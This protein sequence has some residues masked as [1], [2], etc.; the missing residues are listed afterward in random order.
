MKN[1][2]ELTTITDD[3]RFGDLVIMYDP[4]DPLTRVMKK[5]KLSETLEE[6]QQTIEQARCRQEIN[7]P[8][9]LRLIE[10]DDDQDNLIASVYFEFPDSTLDILALTHEEVV[11]LFHDILQ[12]IVYL[13]SNKM[14]HGDIR[15]DY[16]TFSIR[17]NCYKLLDRLG[18]FSNPIQCQLNNINNYRTLYMAP[19]VFNELMKQSKKIKQNSYKSESF[20]LGM[21]VLS[22]YCDPETIQEIYDFDKGVFNHD[23][24]SEVLK[25]V[26][27]QM[28]D[29]LSQKFVA[30][31]AKNVLTYE[32]KDRLSPQDSLEQ[33]LKIQEVRSLLSNRLSV[34]NIDQIANENLLTSQSPTPQPVYYNPFEFIDKTSAQARNIIKAELYGSNVKQTDDDP[35][36]ANTNIDE[37]KKVS[38]T[39]QGLYKYSETDLGAEI[40]KY[41]VS[42][43]ESISN[44]KNAIVNSRTN[45]ARVSEA[46]IPTTS[47][48]NDVMQ[49]PR[50]SAPPKTSETSV[51]PSVA[52][53]PHIEE[54]KPPLTSVQSTQEPTNKQFDPNQSQAAEIELQNELVVNVPDNTKAMESISQPTP[55]IKRAPTQ[56]IVSLEHLTSPANKNDNYFSDN[57]QYFNNSA[58]TLNDQVI[59][60]YSM[61]E[62]MGFSSHVGMMGPNF[63]LYTSMPYLYNQN[64]AYPPITNSFGKQ[65]E[66][67]NDSDDDMGQYLQSL[68]INVEQELKEERLEDK[69]RNLNANSKISAD[70]LVYREMNSAFRQA[71]QTNPENKSR[72]KLSE[73]LRETTK[74]NRESVLS[75]VDKTKIAYRH[76]TN[77][78][79]NESERPADLELQRGLSQNSYVYQQKRISIS[80]KT[81]QP[82]EDLRIEFAEFDDAVNSH[83]QGFDRRMVKQSSE[84]QPEINP[85]KQLFKQ[86]TEPPGSRV[87]DEVRTDARGSEQFGNL[88]EFTNQDQ[89]SKLRIQKAKTLISTQPQNYFL[90]KAPKPEQSIASNENPQLSQQKHDTRIEQENRKQNT[91]QTHQYVDGSQKEK[92]ESNQSQSK[93]NKSKL[94]GTL[95]KFA[96]E[97]KI[98]FDNLEPK[99]AKLRS[100]S[101]ILAP[102]KKEIT[103]IAKVTANDDQMVPFNPEN[104]RNKPQESDNQPTIQKENPLSKSQQPT[105]VTTGHS[106]KEKPIRHPNQPKP[107]KVNENVGLQPHGHPHQKLVSAPAESGNLYLEELKRYQPHNFARP[108]QMEFAMSSRQFENNKPIV[109]TGN[110]VLMDPSGQMLGPSSHRS[111][112]KNPSN[113]A[114]AQR[115]TKSPNQTYLKVVPGDDILGNKIEILIPKDPSTQAT[116]D[117]NLDNVDKADIQ[118]LQNQ[119]IFISGVD[120]KIVDAKK[121]SAATNL[122]SFRQQISKMEA[123]RQSDSKAQTHLEAALV[124]KAKLNLEQQSPST[125]QKTINHETHKQKTLGEINADEMNVPKT[126][127]NSATIPTKI[128]FQSNAESPKRSEKI[129][130]VND[131]RYYSNKDVNITPFPQIPLLYQQVPMVPGTIV[132]STYQN[133]NGSKS[134]KLSVSKEQSSNQVFVNAPRGTPVNGPGV[135]TQE[136]FFYDETPT[137]TVV[138]APTLIPNPQPQYNIY[139][140]FMP[141]TNPRKFV[142][143][144]HI[145]IQPNTIVFGKPAESEKIVRMS[146]SS[147]TS[148]YMNG[149]NT[150]TSQKSVVVQPPPM[151]YQ[152]SMAPKPQVKN[153]PV[154]ANTV[155]MNAPFPS[156]QSSM[157]PVN[158]QGPK[159]PQGYVKSHEIVNPVY[160]KPQPKMD[161]RNFGSRP[162]SSRFPQPKHQ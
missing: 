86:S 94:I 42:N 72:V 113:R 110:Q 112:L 76:T 32:E 15:S 131:P 24:F 109:V 146:H 122:S 108:V 85:P 139:Q 121:N 67:Q 153:I 68:G 4:N 43:P 91:I 22:Y 95:K 119:D 160:L 33:L 84:P 155:W 7:H 29:L 37:D 48:N 136:Y 46:P 117:F 77:L 89:E 61:Y 138:T 150:I 64:P 70:E 157:R 92:T 135:T 140:P 107:E 60:N 132:H 148:G 55:E 83:I 13:Q 129:V 105:K 142:S 11:L 44:I 124:D 130:F 123:K 6:H 82:S 98:D 14:I 100:K 90:H 58:P 127:K 79:N 111:P 96:E 99:A 31:L 88:S 101:P 103:Q 28:K 137:Q 63:S 38:T 17:E 151:L 20:A 8:N 161:P 141:P 126:Y 59:P 36:E 159:P 71:N 147:Q 133:P 87:F 40:N 21:N 114:Q 45:S 69:L 158:I 144:Q 19:I 2:V 80:N 50:Q 66:V 30:Y 65:M 162:E 75:E 97:Y 41:I 156:P 143:N 145:V 35:D 47:T 115:S 9:I 78:P 152:P 10:V 53:Q 154:S 125:A 128:H 57:A 23:L 51:K 12:A 134:V 116:S 3:P 5:T 25:Q 73:F 26:T 118:Q 93:N 106:Q 27:Q 52:T 16:I 102:C 62:Q 34:S 81:F 1:L 49:T 39:T 54:A 120:N 56:D 74:L 18:D 149:V 104:G